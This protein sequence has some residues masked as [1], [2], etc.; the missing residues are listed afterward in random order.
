MHPCPSHQ[1]T[2][3]RFARTAAKTRTG[4]LNTGPVQHASSAAQTA[5]KP[6]RMSGDPVANARPSSRWDRGA[7]CRRPLTRRR[8]PDIDIEGTH[9]AEALPD[10][11]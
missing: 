9:E 10:D 8:T 5:V 11:K 4:G 7:W 2:L 3:I 1:I 6:L